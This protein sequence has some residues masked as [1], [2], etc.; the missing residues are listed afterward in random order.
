MVK[1]YPN[2]KE[3]IDQEYYPTKNV[4]SE[5]QHLP[6]E[7]IQQISRDER[8]PFSI[9]LVNLTGDLNIG[10]AIRTAVLTGAERVI[11]IGRNRLDARSLVGSQNYIDIHKYGGFNEDL[12][13]DPNIFMQAMDDFNLTPIFVETDGEYLHTL[14]FNE[15]L[16]NIN[17]CFCFGSESRG[18]NK[19]ILELGNKFPGSFKVSIKQRKPMRSLN[20]SSAAAIIMNKAM[21]HFLNTA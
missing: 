18:F 16:A 7:E 17:P 14:D 6:L 2:F 11:I 13:I 9:A 12:S 5:L 10:V 4:L 21:E 20:V 8:F 15:K 1:N 19:N 3:V